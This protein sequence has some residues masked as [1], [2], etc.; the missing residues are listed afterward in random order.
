MEQ[1]NNQ[2]F[3]NLF[4]QFAQEQIRQGK[5]D[6]GALAG[7][8]C[9]TRTQLNRKVK[10]VSGLTSTDYIVRMRVKMAKDLL[11]ND[12]LSVKEVAYRCG[13]EDVPYFVTMFKKATGMT[14][15]QYRHGGG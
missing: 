15:G 14:P 8:F 4:E 9:I 6:L 2:Q 11:R 7:Q 3:I 1:T 13:I 5:I 12:S 10:A